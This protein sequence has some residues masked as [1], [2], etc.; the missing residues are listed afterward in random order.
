MNTK[1][2]TILGVTALALAPM[3]SGSVQAGPSSNVA[4]TV[5]TINMIKSADAEAGKAKAAAC[6]SCH[7]AEGIAP[8]PGWPSLAG[9]NANYTYKQ[10]VDYKDRTRADMMMMGMV[11][12]S[13]QQDMADIAA[14]YATLP[15]PAAKEA[16]G[17]MSGAD[18]MV[19]RG[20]AD[21]DTPVPACKSCHG[22][23]GEGQWV[24]VPALAGQNAAYTKG[25]MMKYKNGSRGNDVYSVMRNIAK[26]LSDEEIG[27]LADYYAAMGN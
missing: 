17:D 15:L 19:N 6:G 20:A 27:A 23:S 10:L 22:R 21:R 7:G 25:T 11:M 9:Q 16:T 8:N 24:G 2:K 18:V 4:Y 14:Y 13:S 3:L 12:A 1:M 26:S 5:D